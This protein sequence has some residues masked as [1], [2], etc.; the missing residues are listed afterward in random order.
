MAAEPPALPL[1]E[2]LRHEQW[3]R[4]ILAA[5]PNDLEKLKEWALQL[6]LYAATHRQLLLAEMNRNLPT[7]KKPQP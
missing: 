5:G 7:M 1:H 4:M 2:S 6:L 3:R